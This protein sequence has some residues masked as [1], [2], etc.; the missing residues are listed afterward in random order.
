MSDGQEE[1][2]G[3]ERRIEQEKRENRQD[4]IEFSDPDDWQPEQVDS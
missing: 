2:E 1:R 3:L 4:R